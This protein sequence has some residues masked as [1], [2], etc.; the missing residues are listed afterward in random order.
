MAFLSKAYFDFF[1]ELESN[2]NKE[3]FDVH[4]AEYE[5]NVKQPFKELTTF[6]IEE[7]S[8]FDNTVTRDVSKCIFRI[9]KDV[10]FSK[11]KSPYKLNMAAVFGE[12][13]KKTEKP[14]YYIHIG[15][16]ELFIGG[17]MYAVSKEDLNKI[18]Q[19]IFYNSGEFAAVLNKAE[20]KKYFGEIQGEKN[21]IVPEE[22]REFLK[23]QPYIANKQFYTGAVLSREQVTA[24]GFEQK[25]IDYF[26]A[27]KPL[28]DFL[29]EAILD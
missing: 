7:I 27:V 11:D 15:N 29:L 26:K 4:R 14:S 3:W 19:E 23:K 16:K 6:L 1:D 5:H 22:Y 18:R 9:N 10:R 12:N 25:V 2:N 24:E 17:G 8:R 21:K 28:N 20:F 13:G